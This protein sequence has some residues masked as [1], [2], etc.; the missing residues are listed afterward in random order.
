M[1]YR[2]FILSIL[3]SVILYSCSKIKPEEIKSIRDSI[4]GTYSFNVPCRYQY[5]NPGAWLNNI[6]GPNGMPGFEY[7]EVFDRDTGSFIITKA[8]SKDSSDYIYLNQFFTTSFT[9]AFNVGFVEH[10]PP[11]TNPP[12]WQYPNNPR[13]IVFDR[14]IIKFS[15]SITP[16]V[17]YQ[18]SYAWAKL[19]DSAGVT[20]LTGVTYP[21]RPDVFFGFLVEGSGI[22]TKDSII[23]NYHSQYRPLHKYSRIAVARH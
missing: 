10:G 18:S 23:I 4:A 7:G 15:A 12:V 19:K 5:L 21:N 9:G 17:M 20:Y 1:R 8:L 14:G 16:P 6:S 22:I 11:L 3:L 13:T 2:L